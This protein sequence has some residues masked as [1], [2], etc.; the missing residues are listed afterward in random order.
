MVL[1]GTPQNAPVTERLGFPPPTP[2]QAQGAKEEILGPGP[3][4]M[5]ITTVIIVIAD[6]TESALTTYRQSSEPL[7]AVTVSS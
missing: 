4:G 5:N 6:D 1:I 7:P 2:P 3:R